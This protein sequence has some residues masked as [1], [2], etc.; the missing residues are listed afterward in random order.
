[1]E[2]FLLK[3]SFIVCNIFRTWVEEGSPLQHL[4]RSGHGSMVYDKY[5]EIMLLLL[6]IS[7]NVNNLTFLHFI[8]KENKNV[9]FALIGWY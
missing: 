4:L 3:L 2:S 8:D 9:I 1:M 5:L 6:R 7:F